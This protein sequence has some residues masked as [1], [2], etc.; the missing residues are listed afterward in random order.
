MF[1]ANQTAIDKSPQLSRHGAMRM[2]QRGLTLLIVQWL[3]EFGSEQYDGHGVSFCFSIR[4]PAALSNEPSGV[5]PYAACTN[6][7]MPTLLSRTMAL[8][9]LPADVT[10][11]CG[12]RPTGE[13]A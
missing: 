2:Q 10:G 12:G 11:G 5:S 1:K 8:S 9:S 7:S 3:E 4:E 13:M 6:G